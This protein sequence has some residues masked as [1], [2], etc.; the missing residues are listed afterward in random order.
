MS[1]R[2]VY[3][4]DYLVVYASESGNTEQIANEIYSVLPSSSKK[5]M[6]VRDW[7]GR[8]EADTYFIGF[9]ANR[10]TCSLEIIDLISSLKYK[11]AAFFGTCGMGNT[12]DYYKGIENSALAWLAD[13]NYYLGGYFCQGKMPSVIRDKYEACRGKCE[14]YLLDAMIKIYEE[15]QKHPDKQDLLKANVFVH[16]ALSRVPENVS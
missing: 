6:N 1:E 5:I 8:Y 16:D 9:W 7:N 15:G 2:G 3:M 12:D 4:L 11:N 13:S 10:G 14:P